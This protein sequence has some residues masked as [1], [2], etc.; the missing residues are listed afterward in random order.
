MPIYERMDELSQDFSRALFSAFPAW[1]QLAKS[2]KDG[3]TGASYIE[4]DIEQEGTNRV[5]H[6]STADD[7]ITISFEQW[8]THVGR[9][10]GIDTKE[11]VAMAM[12]ILEGFVNE[13]TVVKISY[14]DGV[15]RESSLEHLVAPSEPK[16]HS[17]TEVFSWLGTY[18]ETIET[19]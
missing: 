15:W 17:T 6:L 9:F 16:P 4:V 13:Q 2:V 8:H 12:T 7:E 11:S 5:L 19:P 10:L 3:K 1:E 18:D 14:V